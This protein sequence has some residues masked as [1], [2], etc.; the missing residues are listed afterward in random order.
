MANANYPLPKF[1]FSVQ[2]GGTKIAFTEVSGLNK[3]MELLE[4]RYGN[5]PEFFKQKMPGMVKISNI[6]LKRGIFAG[7]NEFYDWYNTVAMN[8]VERRD[9]TITLLDENHAPVVVWQVKDCF[10]QNLKCT[11]LKSD[12]NELGIDTVEIAN[13]GF[14]M[15]H[16]A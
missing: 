3:E 4:Y 6:T 10:I 5:S 11:D 9:I 8:L 14:T 15:E 12:V 16:V 13:H 2:W 7:D 1:H